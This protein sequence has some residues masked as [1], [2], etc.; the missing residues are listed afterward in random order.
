MVVAIGTAAVLIV[1]TLVAVPARYR[2][3]DESR[4]R[5]AVW[6]TDH[7][8]SVMEDDAL[9]VSWWS[10]STPLWYAQRVEGRRPDLAI[11]DDRTIQ[12]LELG[13]IY[14]VIDQ[15][16]GKRPVYVIRDDQQ[17]ID[18]LA[19]R[20]ELEFI[21]GNSARTLTRVIGLK[22]ATQ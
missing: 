21:D 14:D 9:I 15:N 18:E 17:Q 4:D 16:L 11:M 6:W 2:A 19:R 1:P 13:D 5:S 3:V 12:D 8:L 22:A 7:A 10:Y 20:Y